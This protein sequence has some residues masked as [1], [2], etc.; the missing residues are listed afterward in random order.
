LS[1]PSP[2]G[3][4]SSIGEGAP[5]ERIASAGE[6]RVRFDSLFRD[7]SHFR[8]D[9]RLIR[10]AIRRGRLNDLSDVERAALLARFESAVTAREDQ[11]FASQNARTRALLASVRVA[12]DVER[13]D[14]RDAHGA[15]RTA[16]TGR[17]T[18]GRPRERWYVRDFPARLDAHR[19]RREALADGAD[20]RALRAVELRPADKPSAPGVR[21]AL[22][23]VSDALCGWR[24]LLICPRCNRRRVFLYPTRRGVVC[25]ACAGIRHGG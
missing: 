18:S 3:G 6:P 14:L 12:L 17:Y 2:P 21:I 25:R 15:L 23:V 20:P 19:L 10:T 7:T 5:Q 8:G 24:V 16:F 1:A 22:V 4:V 11:G 13:A 9:C